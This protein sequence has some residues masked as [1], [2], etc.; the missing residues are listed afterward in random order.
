MNPV[1]EIEH[2]S[3]WYDR[4]SLVIRD[5]SFSIHAGEAVG[6]IGVNGA[7]KTTMLK[8]LCKRP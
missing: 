8:A 4:K 3:A 1:L 5:A 6:L 2:L 7:G